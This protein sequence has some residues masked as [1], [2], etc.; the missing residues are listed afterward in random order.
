MEPQC[1]CWGLKDVTG[2]VRVL[3]CIHHLGQVGRAAQTRLQAARGGEGLGRCGRECR[4][5]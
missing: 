1:S 4:G 3:F 2:G 5:A